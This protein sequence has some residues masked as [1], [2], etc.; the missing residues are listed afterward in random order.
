MNQKN[1]DNYEHPTNISAECINFVVLAFSIVL[2][3]DSN[4]YILRFFFF[5]SIFPQ[6]LL[7]SVS[8]MGQPACSDIR[9]HGD[10]GCIIQ[11]PNG[12]NW[13]G[14]Y[15]FSS[16]HYVATTLKQAS[17][18]NYKGLRVLFVLRGKVE[19]W[20]FPECIPEVA[21][22]SQQYCTFLLFT[23]TT[24]PW[25][26]LVHFN[27]ILFLHV[28]CVSA[29]VSTPC[30]PS[31]LFHVLRPESNL[32]QLSKSGLTDK[33]IF[34]SWVYIAGIWAADLAPNKRRVSASCLLKLMFSW[35]EM[36]YPVTRIY[37]YSS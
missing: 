14:H 6:K 27:A 9:E 33:L 23:V 26:S 15:S 13:H 3:Y 31:L 16:M 18:I 10:C 24:H 32:Q 2:T 35:L 22:F 1:H 37:L 19:G 4:G 11:N 28:L 17:Q 36:N 8:G 20:R 12:F 25:S 29:L 30:A 5:L 21:V 34:S 7:L